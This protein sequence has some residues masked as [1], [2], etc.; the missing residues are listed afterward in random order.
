LPWTYVAAGC[1][2]NRDTVANINA[3]PLEVE[4]VEQWELP[5]VLPL[6]RPAVTGW[7]RKP[8]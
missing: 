5:K 6:V 8:G 2:C 1:N 4:S 3:S 7:A